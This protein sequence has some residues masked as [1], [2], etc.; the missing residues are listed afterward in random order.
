MSLSQKCEK[1]AISKVN[2][3]DFGSVAILLMDS[4]RSELFRGQSD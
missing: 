4:G 3:N 1:L 2:L